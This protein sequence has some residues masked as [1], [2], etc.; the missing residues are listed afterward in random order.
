MPQ[1]DELGHLLP[2]QWFARALPECPARRLMAALLED[3]LRCLNKRAYSK[4]PGTDAI[5]AAAWIAGSARGARVSFEDC[6]DALGFDAQ[7]IRARLKALRAQRRR[8][9]I[10]RRAGRSA[11]PR[12]GAV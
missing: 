7:R 10:V 11:Q 8:L 2:A 9:K 4:R 1:I 3:A 5:E 12:G 6:C